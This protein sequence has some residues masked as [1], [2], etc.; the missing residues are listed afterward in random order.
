MNVSNLSRQLLCQKAAVQQLQQLNRSK[1]SCSKVLTSAGQSMYSS[2]NT[3]GLHNTGYAN[4]MKYHLQNI[5]MVLHNLIHIHAHTDF[6]W[7]HPL[8]ASVSDVTSL[9]TCHTASLRLYVV[10]HQAAL[11][12]PEHQ[13]ISSLLCFQTDNSLSELHT[14]LQTTCQCSV[15]SLVRCVWDRSN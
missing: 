14:S 5:Y 1:M 10:H 12:Q 13:P 3:C 8:W 6:V 7:T 11:S 4:I 2:D 15:H 9:P